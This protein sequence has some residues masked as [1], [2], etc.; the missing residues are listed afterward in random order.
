MGAW[1]KK[2]VSALLAV[3]R[4]IVS[5]YK[6]SNVAYE[7]LQKLQEQ[8]ELSEHRLIQDVPRWNSSF[9]MLQR[10]LEQRV[11]LTAANAELNVPAELRNSQW[12]LADKVVKLLQIF[13][14]ATR[15]VCGN[16][17]SAALVIPIVNSIYRALEVLKDDR[18]I[19]SMKREMLQ[20]LKQWYDGMESNS[21]YCLATVL[22]PRFKL[23]VFSSTSSVAFCKQM[24]IA[25][26]ET[27]T[28]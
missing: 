21:F 4:R 16:Y 10:L 12:T 17:S 28:V 6:R 9:Y 5:F 15:E 18:G 3:G 19:M 27:L 7:T 25:E 24:L 23:L 26:N 2:D 14:E 22:D 20:S 8:L 13:E 1:H 11:A